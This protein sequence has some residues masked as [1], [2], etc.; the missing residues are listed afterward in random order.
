MEL[1]KTQYDAEQEA[2]RARKQ[3][4]L[5]RLKGDEVK[6]LGPQEAAHVAREMGRVF[7]RIK[8]EKP[9]NRLDPNKSWIRKKDIC[10]RAWPKKNPAHVASQLRRYQKSSNDQAKPKGGW[11]NNP[12]EYSALLDSI[13]ELTGWDRENLYYE[14]FK[15]TRCDK[16]RS[17]ESRPQLYNLQIERQE[18]FI[19]VITDL[20][21]PL[22]SRSDLAAYFREVARYALVNHCY[23]AS[24][25]VIELAPAINAEEFPWL[26]NQYGYA[27]RAFV[28][29]NASVPSA[30]SQ[31]RPFVVSGAVPTIPLCWVLES[32][33]RFDTSE[34]QTVS[35]PDA[36]FAD[37]G[38][39]MTSSQELPQTTVSDANWEV[40]GGVTVYSADEISLGLAPK[41]DNG[42]AGLVLE[43]KPKDVMYTSDGAIYVSDPSDWASG[44]YGGLADQLRLEGVEV[45]EI[46]LD[47]YNPSNTVHLVRYPESPNKRGGF[48]D[49][50][51]SVEYY[52]IERDEGPTYL[53][54]DSDSVQR[55]LIDPFYYNASA[56]GESPIETLYPER[57]DTIFPPGTPASGLFSAAH[58]SRHGR[59]QIVTRMT[60]QIDARI[61]ALTRFQ[62]RCEQRLDELYESQTMTDSRITTAE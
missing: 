17:A 62:I 61:R 12:L 3:S 33:E 42:D 60:Q 34:Q 25:R 15:G 53:S 29:P 39:L 19:N 5:Q 7:Q 22:A 58:D 59:D 38:A 51:T 26:A 20:F 40:C 48:R 57:F 4:I 28:L 47:P 54:F 49:I 56:Q 45:D 41:N 24:G 32:W 36:Y 44:T 43:V 21:E 1:N 13:S 52:G 31:P 16:E 18:E 55:L 8:E 14:V 35:L 9:K 6:E 23:A 37:G 46:W 10:K 2:A 50:Q 27:T 11:V 30:R